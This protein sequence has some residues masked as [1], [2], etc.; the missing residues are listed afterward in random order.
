MAALTSRP[1]MSHISSTPSAISTMPEQPHVKEAAE[2]RRAR[3]ASNTSRPFDGILES[4][5]RHTWIIPGVISAVVFL[6]WLLLNPF[7]EENPLRPFVLLSYCIVNEHGD[8]CYGK[9]PKDFMF[10]AFYVAVFTFIRELTMEQILRPL[11]QKTGLRKSKQGRFM[12]QAFSIIHFTIGG[13]CGLVGLAWLHRLTIVR[14]V[15]NSNVVHEHRAI[16][17]DVPS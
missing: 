12:E 17:L 10:F 3:A 4:T 5:H 9:G 15:T 1:S 13:L 14:H 2:K 8:I 6:S 11:A 7:N 16:L